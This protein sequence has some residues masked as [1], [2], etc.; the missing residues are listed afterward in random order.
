MTEP[1]PPRTAGA[2]VFGS[3]FALRRDPIGYLT[4]TSDALGD[5]VHFRVGP[6]ARA[7]FF[8]HPDQIR[9]VLVTHQHSFMKGRGSS[10]PSSSWER[11]CSRARA[12]SIGASGGSLS[13]PSAASGSRP[14]ERS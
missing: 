3:L 14:T 1:L 7:F 11:G 10:G 8:R 4:R 2:P 5:C 6:R 13:L 9:D 12:S